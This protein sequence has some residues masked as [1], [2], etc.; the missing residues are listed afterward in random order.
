MCIWLTCAKR[1][2]G[3][4]ENSYAFIRMQT[5]ITKLFR[6][7]VIMILSVISEEHALHKLMLQ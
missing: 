4:G 7:V 6:R 3:D 2:I 5:R 1:L